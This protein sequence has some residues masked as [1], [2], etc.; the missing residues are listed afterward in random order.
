MWQCDACHCWQ[1]ARCAA[2]RGHRAPSRRRAYA[3]GC[4]DGDGRRRVA[5]VA[6]SGRLKDGRALA[7]ALILRQRLGDLRGA[8]DAGACAPRDDDGRRA[9]AAADAVAAAYGDASALAAALAAETP[10]AAQIAGAA[11]RCR[12]A[13]GAARRHFHRRFPRVAGASPEDRADLDEH[14]RALFD[15]RE[16][17]AAWLAAVAGAPPAG[18]NAAAVAAVLASFPFGRDRW[19][20]PDRGL[21]LQWRPL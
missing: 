21:S 18:D 2:A 6:P 5:L 14:A 20:P 13:L 19:L 7:N 11:R 12:G 4:G 15:G 10:R 1:H 9:A 17:Y 8:F 16:A 3:C